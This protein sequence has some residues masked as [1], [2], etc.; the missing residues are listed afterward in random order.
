MHLKIFT[1]FPICL[2]LMVILAQAVQAEDDST[3]PSAVKLESYLSSL[4]T[5]Q[6]EVAVKFKIDENGTEAPF[7]NRYQDSFPGDSFYIDK[8][9]Y[10]GWNDSREI[11]R[12]HVKDSWDTSQNAGFEWQMPYKARVWG[13]YDHYD[14]FDL[15][16]LNRAGRY[17]LDTG[18]EAGKYDE[19]VFKFDYTF[20]KNTYQQPGEAAPS[21][22][23]DTNDF[24]LSYKFLKGDWDSSLMFRQRKVD[25]AY[26]NDV[27]H[28]S[29][30]FKTGHDFGDN[31]LQGNIAYTTSDVS[32][33]KSLNSFILGGYG[34]FANALGVDN[35]NISSK[36]NW[37][38]RNSG[39]ARTHPAG[40]LFNFNLTGKWLVIPELRLNGS[41][42]IYRADVSHPD[43]VAH[44]EFR[45]HPELMA[46]ILGLIMKDTITTN[47]FAF[48]GMWR[49]TDN[50]EANANWIWVN[51]DGLPETGVALDSPAALVWDDESHSSYSLRYRMM[52]G[53]RLGTSDW[54]L[55]YTTDDRNNKNKNT[56]SDVDHLSINW[57]GN[58]DPTLMV[59]LGAGYLRTHSV[60]TELATYA[61]RGKE[62][63]GGLEWMLAPDWNF[64]ADYWKYDVS[65]S[66]DYDQTDY[67]TGLSYTYD[68]MTYELL[69][70]LSKGDFDGIEFPNYKATMLML[71]VSLK[72]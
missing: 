21:K 4:T 28:T 18:I 40:D 30:M 11:F 59:H 51:R 5:A 15:P 70:E 27:T 31:Y 63:G 10:R 58:L 23:W 36:V 29:G 50:L 25:N 19:G 35:L 2:L 14:H 54:L 9:A 7:F 32:G 26:M 13:K 48:G 43:E 71:K 52:P 62:F 34:R 55:K 37:N 24:N 46:P 69:Y 16:V 49:I 60:Q 64:Y 12:I 39:V 67:G 72:F 57:T 3:N 22:L 38:N 65:H 47:R 8:F 33:D 6:G 1:I 41:W 68:T 44:I 20:Y 66:G 17:W 53:W 61:Q 42:D 56:S 45:A